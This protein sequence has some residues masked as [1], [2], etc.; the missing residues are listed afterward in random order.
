MDA[1]RSLCSRSLV[2]VEARFLNAIRRNNLV[3]NFYKCLC[4]KL[5]TERSGSFQNRPLTRNST[6]LNFQERRMM[7]S[8]LISA[9][10]LTIH[11]DFDFYFGRK[12]EIKLE[13]CRNGYIIFRFHV[14][15][16]LK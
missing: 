1:F 12:T 2:V 8:L 3:L 9:L 6:K 4:P 5:L 10:T 11:L 14:I 15:E 7:R 13:K 16:A